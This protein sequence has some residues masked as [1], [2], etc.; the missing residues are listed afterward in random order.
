MPCRRGWRLRCRGWLRARAVAGRGRPPCPGR[1]RR[2]RGPTA[3]AVA[4]GVGHL[5]VERPLHREHRREEHGDPKQ[6][7][8]GHAQRAPVGV[9]RERE[10]HEHHEGERHD[11]IDRD[12]R[13]HS[14]R[15]SLPAMSA[16]SRNMCRLQH[17]VGAPPT[18][19]TVRCA[20]RSARRVR[21]WRAPPWPLPRSPRRSTRRR[22]RGP[23]RRDPREVR[24]EAIA[25]AGARPAR[26]G[27][28]GGVGPPKTTDR[29]SARR[30][31]SPRP[32]APRR[33]PPAKHPPS[34]SRT[35]RSPSR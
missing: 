24:R 9:E 10:E 8:R 32:S 18:T 31:T 21:G 23:R 2:D 27:P 20:S 17:R 14:M 34:G 5:D 4:T 1:C 3:Q 16:A 15:R 33:S 26:R 35:S 12:A 7:G 22:V 25:P 6:A 28:Y 29:R 30:P 19:C 11:L 13:R